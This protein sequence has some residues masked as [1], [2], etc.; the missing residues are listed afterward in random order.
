MRS[1][2][3]A[4]DAVIKVRFSRT[5]EGGRLHAPSG[6][7]YACIFVIGRDG[8]D[9][10]LLLN[11]RTLELGV[12]HEVGVKFLSPDLVLPRLS[13]GTRVS[14]REGRKV[15]EGTVLRLM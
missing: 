8:F 13:P 2:P 11:G 4:P 5:D 14:L 1:E 10:R 3:N 7:F 9:G 15:A 6:K 12:E